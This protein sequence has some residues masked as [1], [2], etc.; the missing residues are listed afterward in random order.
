MWPKDP[1]EKQTDRNQAKNA[2]IRQQCENQAVCFMTSQA[3]ADPEG[4]ADYIDRHQIG[5]RPL[6]ERDAFTFAQKHFVDDESDMRPI[7]DYVN[8]RECAGQDQNPGCYKSIS[9]KC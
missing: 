4:L 8:C 9:R 6:L 1:A 2:N 5:A 7:L 3:D